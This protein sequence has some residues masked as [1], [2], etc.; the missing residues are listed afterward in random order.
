MLRFPHVVGL[1]LPLCTPFLQSFIQLFVRSFI[2]SFNHSFVDLIIRT[3]KNL[4]CR[5]VILSFHPRWPFYL[6][7]LLLVGSAVTLDPS[8]R[9]DYAYDNNDCRMTVLVS[10]VFR[11]EGEYLPSAVI[12]SRSHQIHVTLDKRINVFQLL[13]GPIINVTKVFRFSSAT[14]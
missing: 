11:D 5:S 4:F 13:D 8:K 12:E 10:H 7:P 1:S 2:R 9:A 3:F 6:L 14:E